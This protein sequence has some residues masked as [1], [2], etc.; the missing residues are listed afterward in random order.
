[1]FCWCPAWEI[2]IWLSQWIK[3]HDMSAVNIL[4]SM[5]Q[6]TMGLIIDVADCSYRQRANY[7]WVWFTLWQETSADGALARR[8]I[9]CLKSNPIYIFNCPKHEI[10]NHPDWLW[11][12]LWS[13]SLILGNFC[14]IHWA[15]CKRK[16]AT[17]SVSIYLPP[18]SIETQL[19]DIQSF[20]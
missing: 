8:S 14:S 2:I 20:I 19:S 6:W 18:H 7:W 16:R 3:T 5:A 4:I 1:M 9:N 11:E 15:V 10:L 17:S 12:I 13:W